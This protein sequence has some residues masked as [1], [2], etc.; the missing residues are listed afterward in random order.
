MSVAEVQWYQH[1]LP[2]RGTQNRD[3]V[4]SGTSFPPKRGVNTVVNA[5][6]NKQT[7]TQAS[8]TASAQP[9]A[10]TGCLFSHCGAC[11]Q[12]LMHVAA[13]LASSLFPRPSTTH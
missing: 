6:V 7:A 2:A 11:V 1:Y 13:R 12:S 10:G 3:D 9:P 5:G 8:K 4:G